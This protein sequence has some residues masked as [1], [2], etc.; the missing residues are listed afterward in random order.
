MHIY[1]Y[2]GIFQEA[3]TLQ[4]GRLF[5]RHASALKQILLQP[6]INMIVFR[7]FLLSII[8]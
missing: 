8:G 6:G 5:Y 1:I 3:V 4:Q 7:L 2:Y